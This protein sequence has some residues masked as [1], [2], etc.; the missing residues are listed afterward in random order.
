M[1]QE[2]IKQFRIIGALAVHDLQGQ[3]K[4]YEHPY[5]WVVLEP[6]LTIGL[7]RGMRSLFRAF[8]PPD[9]MTP[10]LFYTLGVISVFTF[11]R[12]VQDVQSTAA[13]PS[14]LLIFPSV[15]PVDVALGSALS[16]LCV[17]FT[18]FWIF[19]VPVSIFEGAWPPKDPLGVA[20][21]LIVLYVLAV[22]VGFVFSAATRA[23]PVFDRFSRFFH[24]IMRLTSGLF[25][26][27]TMLPT[28][29][30]PYLT[31]NPVLHLVEFMRADWFAG[32]TS[33]IASWAFILKFTLV[34]LVLGLSLERFMRRVPW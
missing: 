26:V 8:S 20:L 6:V 11:F 14:K 22:A 23:I 27:I 31:W 16:T 28:T 9:N 19:A 34:T 15:T 33:P 1:F 4:Q 10:L 29:A 32:Y 21:T 17:Y 24:R 2:I 12:V 5:V 18:I 30:W 25:F 13:A 3:G 7:L